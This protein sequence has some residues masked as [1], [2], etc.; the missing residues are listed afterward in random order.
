MHCDTEPEAVSD[1]VEHCVALIDGDALWDTLVESDV[2]VV[3]L[4]VAH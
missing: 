1:T 4:T 2:V 3:T